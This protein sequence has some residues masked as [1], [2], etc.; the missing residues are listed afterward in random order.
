M[1][2]SIS[3]GTILIGYL[4]VTK[5]VFDNSL[6]GDSLVS[7]ELASQSSVILNSI[8]ASS[9]LLN[10]I[11]HSAVVLGA[12]NDT[13][14]L[15][16]IVGVGFDVITRFV[17]LIWFFQLSCIAFNNSQ[18]GNEYISTS[19][20]KY[21]A[22]APAICSFAIFSTMQIYHIIVHI[23]ALQLKHHSYAQVIEIL[24]SSLNNLR[25]IAGKR[26]E[27]HIFAYSD[28]GGHL[29]PFC[30]S[31]ILLHEQSSLLWGVWA[32]MVLIFTSALVLSKVPLNRTTE[33]S[34]PI[35]LRSGKIDCHCQ[36]C[37]IRSKKTDGCSSFTFSRQEGV[38]FLWLYS[39]EQLAS[40][41]SE[42]RM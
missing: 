39:F 19:D 11:S 33:D 9:S 25:G 13:Y 40:I 24:N 16:I 4:C 36:A 6:Y 14:V 38:C 29:A 41:L 32:L 34:K 8:I 5:F 20:R 1:R 3:G 28:L 37:S 10:V 2:I 42:A 30:L 23:H 27:D 21:H 31:A 17:G 35:T 15:S 18:G 26:Y 7:G 22:Y 12:L